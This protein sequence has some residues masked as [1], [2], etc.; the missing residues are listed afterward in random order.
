MRNLELECA[1]C[2]KQAGFTLE[3]FDTGN[4][5][6]SVYKHLK[7]RR[8]YHCIMHARCCDCKEWF[9]FPVAVPFGCR[10]DHQ[11]NGEK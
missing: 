2:H 5:V 6:E 11:M 3:L 10:W 1:H 7:D 9:D 8:A 4:V